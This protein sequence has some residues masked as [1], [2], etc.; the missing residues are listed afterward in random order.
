MD[1]V[2]LLASPVPLPSHTLDAR[3]EED[4]LTVDDEISIDVVDFPIRFVFVKLNF[5]TQQ[6][7]PLFLASLRASALLCDR[8]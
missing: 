3:C 4:A 1:T 7:A 8:S 5:E 6:F 2:V